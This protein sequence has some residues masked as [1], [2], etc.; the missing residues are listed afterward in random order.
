[1]DLGCYVLNAARQVGRW[2]D[3]APS[4]ISAEAILKEPNIGRCHASRARP[5]RGIQAQ[6]HWDMN[7]GV[8]RWSGPSKA[9][10][11]RQP[12]RRLLCP[13]WTTGS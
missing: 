1:M 2:L 13:T 5:I 6:L 8:E 10:P 12:C 3:E 7:A 9:Q 4:V 11:G